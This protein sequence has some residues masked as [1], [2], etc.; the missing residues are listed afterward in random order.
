MSS[1]I[2]RSVGQTVAAEPKGGPGVALLLP[3]SQPGPE[4]ARLAAALSGDKRFLVAV[5]YT[6]LDVY[7][8]QAQD[9]AKSYYGG[10]S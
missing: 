8:R 6:H 5:S 10:N 4:L 9:W 2:R 1:E 3:V 7:K